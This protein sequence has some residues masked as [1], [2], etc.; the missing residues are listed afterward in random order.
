MTSAASEGVRRK[1]QRK[2][3][4]T[5]E[6]RRPVPLRGSSSSVDDFFC[7]VFGVLDLPALVMML[8]G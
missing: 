6:S 5:V 2:P 4:N 8:L 3:A 1:L 7:E